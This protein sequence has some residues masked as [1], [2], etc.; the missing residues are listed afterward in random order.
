MTKANPPNVSEL[1]LSVNRT[2]E[3]SSETCDKLLVFSLSDLELKVTQK[4]STLE[5]AVR[6]G[7]V[8][9]LYFRPNMSTVTV[10]ETPEV[11]HIDTSEQYLFIV[12]YR[13]VSTRRLSSEIS[14]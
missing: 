14:F 12:T 11:D 2:S 6:L 8:S 9:M 13:N 3:F 7:A 5:A 10:V 1:N 4:T